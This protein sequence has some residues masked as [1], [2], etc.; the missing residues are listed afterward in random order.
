MSQT[1]QRSQVQ[2]RALVFDVQGRE[3]DDAI[4]VVVSS[5]AVVEVSDG[6]EVLVHSADAI[7][8]QRAPLPIIATHRGGQVN[9]GVV[10]QLSIQGGQLRGM[11]RFGTRQ[12]AAEYRADV[13]NRI[14]RS[15]SVGYARVRAKFR[16]DGVLV[17]E[18]WMP[19]HV[20]MVAEPAD[21]RA[22]F[23]RERPDATGAA[24]WLERQQTESTQPAAK[25]A[26]TP[27]ESKV[28]QTQNAA[29]GEN[30]DQQ[31]QQQQTRGL[32][33]Q[34]NGTTGNQALELER[35]PAR[36]RKPVQG[37]RHRRQPARLLDRRRPEHGSGQR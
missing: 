29:A 12:E 5:D 2:T 35:A 15:V 31:Q 8:L 25:A 17:T 22:G 16:G 26:A 28:D 21:V 30:A 23:Y 6:P 36:H 3:S 19:T 4:P 20:A 11:A 18:R 34:P 24:D 1:E 37:Q 14:I 32:P 7:D 27:Q 10:D 13:I 9:V 33:A